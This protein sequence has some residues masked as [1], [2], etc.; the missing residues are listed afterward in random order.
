MELIPITAVIAVS[1]FFIKEIVELFRKWFERR[2]K[3]KSIKELLK[4]EIYHNFRACK[5][6]YNAI[7]STER[8]QIDP[9]GKNRLESFFGGKL[10]YQRLNE[11]GDIVSSCPL[12]I[13]ELTEFKRLLP[14]IAELSSKD[15]L[16]IR[17]HY[18]YIHEL[19]HLSDSFIRFLT[20]HSEEHLLKGFVSYAY[21]KKDGVEAGIKNAYEKMSGE[22]MPK[23]LYEYGVL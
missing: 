4:Y 21:D 11:A 1:L 2:R 16:M 22:E 19:K 5:R 9:D 7:S 12:D 18:K 15:Y 8:S 17:E 3:I 6:L 23:N 10:L 20:V 14:Q 13:I